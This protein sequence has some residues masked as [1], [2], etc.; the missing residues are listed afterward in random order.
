MPI[1]QSNI[2]VFSLTLCC[3][4]NGN[5]QINFLKLLVLFHKYSVCY[6]TFFLKVIFFNFNYRVTD[7]YVTYDTSQCVNNTLHM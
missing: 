1:Q 5:T 6:H 3:C 2:L 4:Y 7:T